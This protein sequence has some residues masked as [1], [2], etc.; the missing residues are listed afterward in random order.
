MYADRYRGGLGLTSGIADVG[1][2]VECLC[3]VYD[4][5]AGL[6][7]L[8]EYD[9]LRREVYNTITDPITRTNLARIR[10]DP[11]TLIRNQDPFFTMLDK[12]KKD[13]KMLDDIEKV[14]LLMLHVCAACSVLIDLGRYASPF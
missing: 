14:G 5:K 3:G 11:E 9:R 7:I 8:E 12:S 4:N 6:D 2:V 10:R 1:G 13:P